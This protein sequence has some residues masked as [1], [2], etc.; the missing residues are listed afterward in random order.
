MSPQIC[1]RSQSATFSS[2]AQ[3]IEA[4]RHRRIHAHHVALLN[5]QLPRLVADF[6][7]L[8]FGYRATC[9]KLFYVPAACQELA[10]RRLISRAYLSR[11]LILATA[12]CGA[13]VVLSD[14]YS[15]AVLRS[16]A[17]APRVSNELGCPFRCGD[18]WDGLIG[19]RNRDESVV[20]QTNNLE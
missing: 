13:A 18:A 3:Y 8:R 6:P 10:R 17:L 1:H 12:P 19:R 9:S 15:S 2:C 20:V 4:Y 5:E 11:S 16:R 7:H 14:F